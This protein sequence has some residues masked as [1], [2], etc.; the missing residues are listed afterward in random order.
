MAKD[1][2]EA[3]QDWQ[4]PQSLRDIQSFL[5][6][7]NFYRRFI[8]GFSKVNHPLT[9]LTKGDKKDWQ[10]TPAIETAF[11]NLQE[12]ITTVPILTHLTPSASAL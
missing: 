9:E 3:I 10:W 7:A 11:V 4:T 2:T 8:F 6:F 5:G 1:K 12:C